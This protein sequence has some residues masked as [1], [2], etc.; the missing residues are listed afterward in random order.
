[1]M[2]LVGS[3]NQGAKGLNYASY[4]PITLCGIPGSNPDDEEDK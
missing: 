4:M 3:V 1:M 2:N